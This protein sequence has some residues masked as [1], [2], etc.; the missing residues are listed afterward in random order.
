MKRPKTPSGEIHSLVRATAILDCFRADQPELGVREI[1]R[2]LKMSSSTVGRLLT[3][4]CASRILAQDPH[5]RLYR[6]GSKVLSWSAVYTDTLDVRVHARPMLE[7]LHHLTHETVT[8]YILDQDERVCVER[9]ESPQRVRVIVRVGERM[10]L[11]A[12]SAGKAML[13]FA[14]PELLKTIFSRRLERMTN[15]TITSQKK[16]GDELERVRRCGYAVSHAE[17]FTDALGL[18]APIFDAN[19]NVVAALNVAGPNTRFTDS[20]VEKFAPKV[21]QL[22]NQISRLLGYGT[23]PSP[24]K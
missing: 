9:I 21:I 16:L 12:G 2:Q 1:A 20:E 7:E 3:T 19:G 22:A 10:P 11:H 17:R 4:L 13:A 23:S 8:L 6:I 14:S 24:R 5:T 18:A 15:N